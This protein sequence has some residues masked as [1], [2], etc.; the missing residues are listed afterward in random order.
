M[1]LWDVKFHFFGDVHESK[2]RNCTDLFGF[3]CKSVA[4]T[5]RELSKRATKCYDITSLLETLFEYNYRNEI[6][7]DFFL[8]APFRSHESS[9]QF[10]NDIIVGK[11]K[12]GLPLTKF[13]KEVLI[14]DNH[15]IPIIHSVF[16]SCFQVEKTQCPYFPYIRFHYADIRQYI[17][18]D[19]I[20]VMTIGGFIIDKLY[21]INAQLNLFYEKETVDDVHKNSLDI[22]IKDLQLLIDRLYSSDIR[23][24][25]FYEIMLYSDNFLI[26]MTDLLKKLFYGI[27]P[28]T[29]DVFKVI[30]FV[31]NILAFAVMKNNHYISRIRSQYETLEDDDIITKSSYGRWNL[32]DVIVKFIESE[33][34]ERALWEYCFILSNTNTKFTN[35]SLIL[36]IVNHSQMRSQFTSI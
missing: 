9:G 6:Y 25:D 11:L 12:D 31:D 18:G 21:V 27:H 34:D 5:G 16:H 32:A 2:S 7:T 8:E 13:E 29:F 23:D 17:K 22:L 10:I 19:N 33:Y 24:Y 30:E 3:K 35:H 26:D 14:H 36:K 1:N 28:Y 20:E 4:L 15:Y